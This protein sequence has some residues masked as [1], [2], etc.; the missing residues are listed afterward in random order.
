MSKPPKAEE[1]LPAA[2]TAPSAV[3][4]PP[5]EMFFN[6]SGAGLENVSPNDLI[7]PRLTILQGLSPQVQKNKPEFIPGASAG[8]ICDV[9]TG[10]IFEP[11]LL[12]LPVH[13]IKQY[14]EWAPRSS[15]KGLV[16][17]HNN[18]EILEQC[19]IDEKRK[20]WLPNGNYVAETAQFFGFNLTAGGRRS[21][22]PM[23][24]TQLK[25]ARKWLTLATSE[26]I[27][28]KDGTEFTPPLFYR[29]YNL[30]TVEQS[31]NEGS[32]VGWKI[33]RGPTMTELENWN[34]LYK[35]ALEFRE[36]LTKGEVRGD[37]DRDE[38]QS[39]GDE[40]AM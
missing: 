19:E 12:F 20:A 28:R 3:A 8:D 14:L 7:I 5:D 4:L 37:L 10:E 27:R 21:F 13:Y 38:P 40:A 1:T 16:A 35:E 15:G 26:K 25:V 6:D 2:Q 39:S 24:S 33:E 22:L 32:W 17:I 36:S 9:G 11:P 18:D 31:N 30:S 34:A 23:S 29:A